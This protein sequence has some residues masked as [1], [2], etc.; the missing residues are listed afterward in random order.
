M[1]KK[2]VNVEAVLFD[3]CASHMLKNTYKGAWLFTTRYELKV[4]KQLDIG[5]DP[6]C[7]WKCALRPETTLFLA[8]QEIRVENFYC[9][10]PE[11]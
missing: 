7:K 2:T 1:R 10:E 3:P 5:A 8:W 6:C 9:A 11:L 4:L